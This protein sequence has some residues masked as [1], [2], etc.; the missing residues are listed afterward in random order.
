M[1]LIVDDLRD[2]REIY[3]GYLRQRGFT[4]VEASGGVEA[5]AAAVELIPDI[6]VMDLAMPGLDGFETTRVLKTI[7]HTRHI[8]VIALTA[9]GDHLPDV[10]AAAA[11]CDRYIRKP[12]L[13][14]DL[15]TELRLLL[16]EPF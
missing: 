15:E 11:G 12:I 4:V 5:I 10:W 6:V 13:P 8:P 16:R 3:V 1:V 7:L 2:Q 14:M 9:H